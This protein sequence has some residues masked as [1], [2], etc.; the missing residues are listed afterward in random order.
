MGVCKCTTAIPGPSRYPS[1]AARTVQHLLAPSGWP[2]FAAGVALETEEGRGGHAPPT[3]PVLMNCRR[4]HM[5]FQT[6]RPSPYIGHVA[7]TAA[8]QEAPLHTILRSRNAAV[9]IASGTAAGS[10]SFHGPFWVSKVTAG[11]E[12]EI[13]AGVCKYGYSLCQDDPRARSL[14]PW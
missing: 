4:C 1:G 8:S 12:I 10:C 9:Y 6:V 13:E 14:L 5:E 2:A 11:Q 3:L 7:T